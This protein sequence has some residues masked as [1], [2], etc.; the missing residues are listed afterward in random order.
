MGHDWQKIEDEAP[1][2]DFTTNEAGQAC[3]WRCFPGP[4]GEPCAWYVECPVCGRTAKLNKHRG[5]YVH[6]NKYAFDPMVRWWPTIEILLD[7]CYEEAT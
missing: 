5:C 1:I 2:N 6:K 7:Y 3:A 4:A